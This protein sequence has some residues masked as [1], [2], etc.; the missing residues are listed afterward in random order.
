MADAVVLA[1]WEGD[2]VRLGQV[3][4]TMARLRRQTARAPTVTSVMTLIVVALTDADE[5][6]ATA[7]VRIL[8]GHHPARIL[9]VRPDPHGQTGIGARIF[10]WGGEPESSETSPLTV[11]QICLMVRGA[12]AEH[13]RSIIEPFTL[14]DVPV[15][16]WYPG[17]LPDPT[18]GLLA[19]ASAVIVDSKEAGDPEEL[20]AMAGLA[21]SRHTLID[22]S[23][24]RL[25]PWRELVAGLFDGPDFRPLLGAIRSARVEG[26]RGP[27]HLLAGWLVSRLGLGPQAVTLADSAH[28]G[29]R[30]LAATDGLRATIEAAR[31]PGERLVR[32]RAAIDDGAARSTVVA[33]P[34]DNLSWSLAQA[35]T[36]PA[37]DRVWEEALAAALTL[38]P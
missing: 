33:L 11:D 13:L 8:G 12:A 38:E 28:A 37:R 2:S 3:M 4:D 26:K 21:R 29:I 6:R 23:W 31:V 16:L 36:H 5:T 20:A 32:A 14:A 27:R 10:I 19:T 22:L 24:M 7:A 18:A 1:S 15:L 30:L 25:T 35:L 9:M 17:R 34:D